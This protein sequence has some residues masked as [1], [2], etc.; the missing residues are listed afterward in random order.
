MVENNVIYWDANTGCFGRYGEDCRSHCLQLACNPPS[1]HLLYL[2][3]SPCLHPILDYPKHR[4]D[5]KSGVV[6]F[7]FFMPRGL[8]AGLYSGRLWKEKQMYLGLYCE[9]SP[10]VESPFWTWTENEGNKIVGRIEN[11]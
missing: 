3:L 4:G 7:V 2:I 11:L 1:F 8:V 5:G 10:T 9:F 6:F